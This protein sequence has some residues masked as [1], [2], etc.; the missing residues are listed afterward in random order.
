MLAKVRLW[1]SLGLNSWIK[2]WNHYSQKG[3]NA[4]FKLYTT[5]VKKII[6]TINSNQ[7][8]G[9]GPWLYFWLKQLWPKSSEHHCHLYIYFLVVLYL[10]HQ[11]CVFL[12]SG[13]R[14]FCCHLCP[15]RAS[16]KGNLKTHVQS[17]HHM[18]FD[19][20]QYPDTRNSLL[21]QEEAKALS[22]KSPSMP[23]HLP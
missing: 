19:N 8:A 18:P 17:V 20:S 9:H 4:K 7:L 21:N 5:D 22:A 10:I 13:E 16:Q 11:L 3:T 1:N 12:S 15:Y 6:K 14:P 23:Q 2:W